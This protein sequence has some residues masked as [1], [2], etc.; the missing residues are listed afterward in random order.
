ML[1]C[2]L[3]PIGAWVRGAEHADV[4]NFRFQKADL[5]EGSG[6]LGDGLRSVGEGSGDGQRSRVGARKGGS[7]AGNGRSS[8]GGGD[9]QISRSALEKGGD[10]PKKWGQIGALEMGEGD[11]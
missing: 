1:L 2:S 11:F 7:S 4:P 6:D 8:V 3:R 9:G 10:L 5:G